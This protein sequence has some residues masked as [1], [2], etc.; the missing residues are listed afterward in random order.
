MQVST[1]IDLLGWTAYL[2]DKFKTAQFMIYL[3]FVFGILYELTPGILFNI[4]GGKHSRLNHRLVQTYGTGVLG[5]IILMYCTVLKEMKLSDAYQLAT[6]PYIVE[7]L[8]NIWKERQ[9]KQAVGY[10]KHKAALYL[11][12]SVSFLYSMT[13]QHQVASMKAA[14]VTYILLGLWVI[15]RPDAAAESLCGHFPTYDATSRLMMRMIGFNA[16]GHGGLTAA[17]LFG[18]DVDPLTAFGIGYSAWF[19]KLLVLQVITRDIKK[20]GLDGRLVSFWI[21]M[22]GMVVATVLL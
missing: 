17:T 1:Q 6:L 11:V 10:N 18:D 2:P 13:Q 22:H 3:I 7:C 20:A 8:R 19:F 14:A 12:F 15:I 9:P 4:Y 21:L 16:L 5:N